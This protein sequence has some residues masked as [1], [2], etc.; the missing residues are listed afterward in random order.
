MAVAIFIYYTYLFTFIHQLSQ[1]LFIIFRQ[2][3]FFSA[4][5]HL[6]R[7][8]GDNKILV[9]VQSDE[10]NFTGRARLNRTRLIRSFT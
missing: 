5:L 9:T 3:S 1:Q 2:T 4:I 10:I 6:D 8:D 7:Y